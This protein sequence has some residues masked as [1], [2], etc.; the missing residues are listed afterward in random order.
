MLIFPLSFSSLSSLYTSLSLSSLSLSLPSVAPAVTT[1]SERGLRGRLKFGLYVLAIAWTS[2]RCPWL[3]VYLQVCGEGE[4]ERAR[5]RERER[6]ETKRE[7]RNRERER[8]G[9]R[10]EREREKGEKVRRYWFTSDATAVA[11]ACLIN[12]GAGKLGKPCP[13]FTA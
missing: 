10:E 12:C 8:R 2:R 7:R 1:I 4:R 11:A 5:A 13:K 6:R 3:L 9:E